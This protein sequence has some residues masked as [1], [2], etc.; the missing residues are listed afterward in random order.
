MSKYFAKSTGQKGKK[1]NLGEVETGATDIYTALAF[2]APVPAGIDQSLL[3][4]LLSSDSSLSNVPSDMSSI[5]VDTSPLSPLLRQDTPGQ[6][7]EDLSIPQTPTKSA[8]PPAKKPQ[9]LPKVSPYFPKP[10]SDAESCL[11]FPPISAES[12]G[13]IQEQLAHN[14]FRLLLATIFL[15]QTRGGVAIPVLFHV[16]G[17]YPTVEAMAAADLADVIEMIHCLGFQ[18]PAREEMHQARKDMAGGAAYEGEAIPQAQLPQEWRWTRRRSGQVHRRRRSARRMGDCASS[19][20]WGLRDRQLAH[21]L[22]Q[23]TRQSGVRL[24][25]QVGRVRGL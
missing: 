16:F 14:P 5:T 7:A 17:R 18:K 8:Q 4:L 20:R 23:Q 22:P 1:T 25:G 15:N 3:D 6:P 13:L 11:P 9:K 12:F 21:L 10:S 2:G 24:E 19:G